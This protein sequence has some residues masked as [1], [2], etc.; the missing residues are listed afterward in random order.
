M[1]CKQCG[2][3]ILNDS[4]FCENCGAK[5]VAAVTTEAAAAPQ[6]VQQA[7]QTQPAQPVQPASPAQQYP[8]YETVPP[9][10]IDPAFQP[11]QVNPVYPPNSIYASNA[12]A[13]AQA[14]QYQPVQPQAMVSPL[15]HGMTYQQYPANVYQQPV[16]AY[17][18]YAQPQGNR[19]FAKIL[20]IVSGITCGF[21]FL[22]LVAGLL[23]RGDVAKDLVSVFIFSGIS[24]FTLVFSL[25]KKS[26]GK[27]AFIALLIATSL[28]F[29]LFLNIMGLS[30]D[31]IF[32]LCK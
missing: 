21:Y 4:Q 23:D 6:P 9:V 22:W 26:I 7:P 16:P 14:A 29:Y 27:G 13:A 3:Q 31:I 30:N 5:V 2:S 28:S 19:T 12:Y 15:Q 1:F 10:Q 11:I 18:P 25:T 17:A 24:I 8:V 20:S 32:A